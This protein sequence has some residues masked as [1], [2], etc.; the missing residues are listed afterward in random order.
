MLSAPSIVTVCWEQNANTCA[1]AVRAD[2]ENPWLPTCSVLITNETESSLPDA[3]TSVYVKGPDAGAGFLFII[4]EWDCVFRKMK[5]Y[6]N[7]QRTYLDFLRNLSKDR[8]YV[9]LAYMT[10][11]FPIKNMEHTLL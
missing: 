1:S 4:D 5:D 6:E 9:K 7:V 8:I 3:L 10:G 11:I 2:L